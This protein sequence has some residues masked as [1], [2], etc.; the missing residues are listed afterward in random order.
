MRIWSESCEPI[1][2]LKKKSSGKGLPAEERLCG[3]ARLWQSHIDSR[4]D[5]CN[6]APNLVLALARI[7]GQAI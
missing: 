5:S 3:P 2:S 4:A 7:P 6:L 1:L